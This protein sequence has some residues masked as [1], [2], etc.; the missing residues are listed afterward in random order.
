[1]VAADPGPTPGA[2]PRRTLEE[3]GRLTLLLIAGFIG[4][5]GIVVSAYGTGT[6][7]TTT[8]LVRLG[9][10]VT[11]ALVVVVYVIEARGLSALRPWAVAAIRPILLVEILL[12]L[13]DVAM[14]L[15]QGRL[16]V[17]VVTVLAIWAL[18][19]RPAVVPVPRLDRRGAAMVVG[20]IVVAGA[21]IGVDPVL[22]PGGLLDVGQDSLTTSLSIDCPGGRL[23]PGD[24]TVTYRWNWAHA[25]LIA[26]GDDAIVIRWSGQDENG[27]DPYVVKD[28]PVTSTG[29]YPGWSDEMSTGLVQDLA[30]EVP[31]ASNWGIE[32]AEQGYAP[33]EVRVVLQ[34]ASSTPSDGPV[35]VDAT[36]IH[37]GVWR[38]VP[39]E[40]SCQG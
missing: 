3:R 11:V 15:G 17:P 35:T 20:T 29:V 38:T 34:R 4:V 21:V 31:G 13:I 22:R 27:Q 16:N 2:R 28:M 6:P 5:I 19:G 36:Y 40:L 23:P 37:E 8:G 9:L 25:A 10:V 26:D 39:T 12:D 1:M 14:G 32:L 7:Q 30:N 24:L 33:G 18:R